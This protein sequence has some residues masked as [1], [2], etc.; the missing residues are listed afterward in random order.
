L[1]S[2]PYKKEVP[3]EKE[4]D[5]L[6]SLLDNLDSAPAT[7][8]PTHDLPSKKR[9]SDVTRYRGSSIGPSSDTVSKE[10]DTGPSSGPF[11]PSSDGV[12]NASW[13]DA[14]YTGRES[15]RPRK[16]ED[17]NNLNK[18]DVLDIA[19]PWSDSDR[20]DNDVQMT[21]AQ[22]PPKPA[23]VE[24]NEDDFFT[25]PLLPRDTNS[26]TTSSSRRPLVNAASIKASNP[27]VTDVLD[28][29]PQVKTES[30]RPKGLDWQEAA[31]NV[32]LATSSD[33]VEVEDLPPLPAAAKRGKAAAAPLPVPNASKVD[34]LEADGSL[35]FFWLDHMEVN[36]TLHL[37][38]K[39]WDRHSGRHVSGCVTVEGIERNLYVLPKGS[40]RT[41]AK[42]GVDGD[43]QSLAPSYKCGLT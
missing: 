28:S 10:S 40:K 34:A 3:K 18:I 17:V 15:K 9:K 38:G 5:F 1:P 12:D 30:K 16:S 31:A 43:G 23:K 20:G 24:D 42:P 8:F 14:F 7:S 13:P 37:F 26:R 4:E 19:E 2:N 39:V 36:G 27:V 29:K 22:P 6:A 35:R 32:A 21:D 33:P 41:V 11:G 25:T